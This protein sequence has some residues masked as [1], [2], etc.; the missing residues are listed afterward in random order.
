MIKQKKYETLDIKNLRDGDCINVSKHIEIEQT[1]GANIHSL[2]S[3]FF[4]G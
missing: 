2:L 3:W 1:F 4:Y